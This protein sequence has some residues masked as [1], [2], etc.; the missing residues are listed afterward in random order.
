MSSLAE[1]QF[2]LSKLANI[3]ITESNNL[4]L[5]EH[6]VY[7]NLLIKYLKEESEQKGYT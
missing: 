3:S 1:E 7:V 5:F 6:E 2:F 4:P